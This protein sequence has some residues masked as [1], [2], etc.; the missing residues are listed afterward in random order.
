MLP[1]TGE[2]VVKSL[3]YLG[4]IIILIVIAIVIYQKKKK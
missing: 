2:Q 3:P 1:N 4:I